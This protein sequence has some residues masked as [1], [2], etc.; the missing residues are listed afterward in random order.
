MINQTEY[1]CLEEL[2]ND[3]D[4]KF[5]SL[6]EIRMIISAYR[7]KEI[8]IDRHEKTHQVPNF[9]YDDFLHKLRRYNNDKKI[10]TFTEYDN[11]IKT[12]WKYKLS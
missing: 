8:K 5:I 11:V 10:D 3:L 12:K 6:Y 4:Q 2:F 1:G 9:I 7:R